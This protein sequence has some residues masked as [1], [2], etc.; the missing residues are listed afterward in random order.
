MATR[1]AA[2]SSS[3]LPSIMPGSVSCSGNPMG[4]AMVTAPRSR[5]TWACSA[6][7]LR[8][9]FFATWFCTYTYKHPCDPWP[10][11][12]RADTPTLCTEAFAS[13]AVFTKVAAAAGSGGLPVRWPSGSALYRGPFSIVA[14]PASC[15]CR[16]SQQGECQSG[17]CKRGCHAGLPRRCH[18]DRLA[19]GARAWTSQCT[20][21]RCGQFDGA[22]SIR[23]PA[24]E[25]S[26]TVRFQMRSGAAR[27]KHT[28][29]RSAHRQHREGMRGM[30]LSTMRGT[31]CAVVHKTA[32]DRVQNEPTSNVP[33]RESQCHSSRC[34]S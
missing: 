5:S 15:T 7:V 11:E 21:Q 4:Y 26:E 16:Q 22:C 1:T 10:T 29:R 34:R 27:H 32:H 31:R 33:T 8:A 6:E 18:A 28:R 3:S 25:P 2:P 13:S 23:P 9:T 12:Q 19:S 17:A 30:C 14:P 20:H 24:H